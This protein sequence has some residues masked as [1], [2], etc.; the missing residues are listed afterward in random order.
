MS[1]SDDIF[2]Y[3]YIENKLMVPHRNQG[4]EIVLVEHGHL[5]WAVDRIPEVLTPGTVFFTLP[6]QIHGSLMLREPPNRIFY[7]LFSLPDRCND[8]EREICFPAS[9]KFSET[10]QKTLGAVFT[11]AQRHAWPATPLLKE[12]FPELIR[13]LDGDASLDDIA[14]PSL[15]RTLLIE[16]AGIISHTQKETQWLSPTVQKV[17]D[18]LPCVAE[19]IDHAWTLDEMADGCGIKRTHFTNIIKKLTGYSPGQYLQ[20]VRFDRACELLRNTDLSITD[21]TFACGYSS[22]QYFSEA[23]KKTAHMTPSEYRETASDLDA[24]MKVNWDHPERRSLAEEKKR[25]EMMHR[26][27]VE[28]MSSPRS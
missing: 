27:S 9:L 7:T 11:G 20:R 2:S 1:S 26:F 12:L 17:K 28:R 19:S 23:F 3:G 4:M 21:I 25:A 13:R 10:E 5:E 24:I 18:F 22:S 8:L 6:W 16:L 15:L 14:A